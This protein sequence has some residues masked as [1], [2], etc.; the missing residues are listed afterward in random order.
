LSNKDKIEALQKEIEKL[1]LYNSLYATSLPRSLTFS[2]DIQR[3]SVVDRNEEYLKRTEMYSN[4]FV[5]ELVKIIIK[6]AIGSDFNSDKTFTIRLNAELNDNLKKQ[7]QKE[8]DYLTELISDKFNEVLL[9]SQFYGD[10]FVRV[11]FEKGQ[12]VT[13][14]LHNISTKP[15]NIT[16]LI[17]NHLKTI[18]YE[19]GGGVENIFGGKK[20]IIK[21]V[22]SRYYVAPIHIARINAG[23]N[24]VYKVTSLQYSNIEALN[25][26]DEERY[27]TEDAIYGGVMEDVY[28]DY[29]SFNWA[30]KALANARI[31]SAMLERFIIHQLD[32][33][34]DSEKRELRN[35]LENQIKQTLNALG[36]RI[37]EKNPMPLIANHIIPTTNNGT[38]SIQIQESNPAFQG[39]QNIE[40]IMIHIRKF[41]GAI[42]INIEMTSFSGMS[43]GGGEKEGV[44]QNSLQA[45]AQAEEIRASA[46]RYIKEIIRV[47]F[48]AKYNVE[49]DL[50]KVEVD[51]VAVINENKLRAEENRLETITNTQSL[52]QVVEQLK[53]SQIEDTPENMEAVRDIFREMVSD[54]VK[55]KEAQVEFYT[56]LVF[57]KNN[58]EEQ[59]MI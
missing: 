41:L 16:P 51:F 50:S 10:G 37:N 9:D 14:L 1:K 2:P 53:Q 58:E 31:S 3:F 55:N 34:S 33:I 29:I 36:Q 26:F 4:T 15:F 13:G 52:L 30:I 42:G 48:L 46:R 5:R 8:F 56:K 6:R 28:E 32:A 38:N 43:M 19:I 49:I 22:Q 24:G 57:T 18:A 17:T 20:S 23:G 12:G 21:R 39:F 54:A 27:I 11:L 47:H 25:V 7:I 40:D 45:D 44:Y 59:E 35:A